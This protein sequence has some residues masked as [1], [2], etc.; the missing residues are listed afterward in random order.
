MRRI[1]CAMQLLKYIESKKMTLAEF[2]KLVGASEFGVRKWVRGERTPRPDAIRKIQEVTKGAVRPA[3][4]FA[5]RAA[6]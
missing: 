1:L 6:E 2:G 4:F 5:P 3:D